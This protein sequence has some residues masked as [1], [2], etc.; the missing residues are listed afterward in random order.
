MYL[1]CY[2]VGR[3]PNH[4]CH[5]N[6]TFFLLIVAVGVAVNNIKVFSVAMAMQQW[7]NFAL[8]SSYKIFRVAFNNNKY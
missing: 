7:V 8:L 1:Q 5:E 2:I 4:C 3:S 6:A